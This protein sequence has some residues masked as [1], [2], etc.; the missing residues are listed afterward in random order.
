[1]K[2]RKTAPFLFLLLSACASGPR[3]QRSEPLAL[4]LAQHVDVE[5]RLTQHQIEVSYQPSV[6]GAAA[7]IQMAGSPAVA[8]GGFA[9]GAAAGLIGSL[10][11]TAVTV[12]RSNVAKE[13]QRPIQ[14][15]T[16]GLSIDELIHRSL[17]GLDRE[18]IAGDI[19]L[20]RLDRA[21]RD[22]AK[23]KTL[24]VGSNILVLT[25]RYS[26]SYDGSFFSY[27]LDVTLVD[28]AQNAKGRL[29]SKV[30]YWQIFEYVLPQEDAPGGTGWGELGAEQW[31]Q[32]LE[33]AAAETV[34]MLNYDIGANPSDALPRRRY[35]DQTV[36]L[37]QE[38]GE[39][40]WVRNDF[41]LLSVPTARLTQTAQKK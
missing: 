41:A 8:A 23:A 19:A 39:R 3:V 12:H 17:E 29:D 7:G 40:S 5:V 6:Q 37:D 28:R 30:R 4:P 22:D 35:H 24:T 13:Q 1:M 9:A 2:I 14:E 10:I 11:D 20:V 34:T 36:L 33:A 16:S 31:T 25:P 38:R 15:R 26:V 32:V 27:A 21:E 18:R